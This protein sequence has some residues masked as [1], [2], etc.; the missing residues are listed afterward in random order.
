MTRCRGEEIRSNVIV[1]RWDPIISSSGI[2]SSM[3]TPDKSGRLSITSI[4]IGF[5]LTTLGMECVWP[6]STSIKHIVALESSKAVV[7]ITWVPICKLIG[8]VKRFRDGTSWVELII[9]LMEPNCIA[10]TAHGPSLFQVCDYVSP[11]KRQEDVRTRHNRS[12]K[13]VDVVVMHWTT[14]GAPLYPPPSA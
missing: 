6:K 9:W 3:M 14:I 8:T 11:G 2:V 4:G 10:L 1:S 13:L 5:V 7:L 12:T